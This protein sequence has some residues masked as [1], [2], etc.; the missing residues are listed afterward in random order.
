MTEPIDREDEELI[1]CIRYMLGLKPLPPEP[2][3]NESFGSAF[4]LDGKRYLS[5]A[6]WMCELG[7]KR[8]TVLHRQRQLEMA[9][10]QGKLDA[11]QRATRP[12]LLA[13]KRSCAKRKRNRVRK[14]CDV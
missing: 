4:T 5:M 10:E 3:R 13:H 14:R 11:Y 12:V 1:A 8:T 2:T 7:A 9:L 6:E